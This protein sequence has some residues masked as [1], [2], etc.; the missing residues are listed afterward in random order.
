MTSNQ[1]GYNDPATRARELMLDERTTLAYVSLVEHVGDF[2][3]CPGCALAIDGFEIT[4]VGHARTCRALLDGVCSEPAADGVLTH[5]GQ[6]RLVEQVWLTFP[7]T[8]EL[9]GFPGARFR[10]DL[11]SSYYSREGGVQ[12]VVQRDVVGEG[13]ELWLD[14][15]RNTPRE[16]RAQLVDRSAVTGGAR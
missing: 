2:G 6:Q 14:F 3:T 11:R 1:T 9:R 8:F 10:I 7:N 16:I 13:R 5:D 4:R 15:V 12:L